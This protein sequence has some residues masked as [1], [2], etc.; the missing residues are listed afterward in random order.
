MAE[1]RDRA[2]TTALADTD[3]RVLFIALNA[4]MEHCSA[5]AARLIMRRMDQ[6]ELKDSTLRVLGVRAVAAQQTEESLDWLVRRVVTRT[7]WLKRLRL[8]QRSAE[9]LA[10]LAAI[11]GLWRNHAK[12]ATALAL[13]T[14]SAD[15]E[16]RLAITAG[17]VR[18]H[19]REGGGRR[20]EGGGTAP[21]VAAA[22]AAA[23]QAHKLTS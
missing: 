20:A 2:M 19:N 16:I 4:A 9:T 12:S 23:P 15:S 18:V 10:A 17:A 21:Q 8:M 7:R 1:V 3:E 13:A 14:K 11:A 22:P 5:G 6:G